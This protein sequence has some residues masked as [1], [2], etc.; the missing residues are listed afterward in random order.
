M[1]RVWIQVCVS[2]FAQMHVL[3]FFFF[4]GLARVC[5]S[6]TK[7]T[8]TIHALFVNSN[9]TIWLFNLF[10]ATSVGSV[11]RCFTLFYFYFLARVYLSKTKGAAIVH[12]LFVNSSHI[13]WLFNLFSATSVDLCTV[14]KTHKLHFS[15]IFL[16]KMGFMVLFTHLKFI[17]LQYFP[18]LAK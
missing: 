11:H 14:Y 7:C 9:H 6:K 10:S 2:C 18:F 5:L 1:E 12:V 13:I 15:A 17:L 3:L 4:F 8:A 16:L